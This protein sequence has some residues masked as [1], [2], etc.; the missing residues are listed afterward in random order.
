FYIS[1]NHHSSSMINQWGENSAPP[2]STT[3][4]SVS[5]DYFFEHENGGQY[6]DLIKM[7]I[8]GA[9]VY[10][11]KGCERCLE[12]KRPLIL[13]ESHTGL[14]DK[15]VGYVLRNYQYE[16]LRIETNKWILHK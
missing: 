12:K 3:V 16:A 2:T 5:L 1:E 9:G 7:D 6:P 10:A 13:M 14:E 8:E 4:N 15:A 11:L